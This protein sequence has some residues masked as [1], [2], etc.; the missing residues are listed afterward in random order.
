MSWMQTPEEKSRSEECLHEYTVP[1]DSRKAVEDLFALFP[2]FRDSELNQWADDPLPYLVFADFCR[3]IKNH[4]KQHPNPDPFMKK[5]ADFISK[6]YDS[7]N[8]N[9]M[10]LALTGVFEELADDSSTRV[11]ADL[12]SPTASQAFMCFFKIIWSA[13]PSALSKFSQ[14]QQRYHAQ[15]QDVEGH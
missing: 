5:A 1:E 10:D 4:I 12:L 11:L 2:E 3:F 7:E 15:G 8:E 9:L 6:L 14:L 13:A